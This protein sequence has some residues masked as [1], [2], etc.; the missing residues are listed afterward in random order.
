[1]GPG[2]WGRLGK[3]IRTHK[4]ISWPEWLNRT[5]LREGTGSSLRFPEHP[6]KCGELLV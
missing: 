4:A 5:I 1:M 6:V 2:G 3:A